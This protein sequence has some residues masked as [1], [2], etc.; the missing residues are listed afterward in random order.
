LDI[1][2]RK[3]D[4]T[5]LRKTIGDW[6]RYEENYLGDFYPLSPY[7]TANDA[8]LAWQFDRPEGG[9]G[10]VQAFR[11]ANSIYESARVKLRG[12]D[13]KARYAVTDI[14]HPANA[15]EVTGVELAERGLLVVA[16][17]QPA[18]MVITYR[19]VN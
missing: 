13:P 19:K 2:D 8:W 14:D 7:T 10:V 11:R 6:R 5:F 16:P 17:N 9:Q 18:A 12:L 1:R 15:Q 3:L 4:F